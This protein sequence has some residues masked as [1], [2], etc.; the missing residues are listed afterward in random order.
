V[1]GEAFLANVR[2]AVARDRIADPGPTPVDRP[3]PEH[4]TDLIATFQYNLA[5]VGGTVYE[6]TSA[7]DVFETIEGI[8]AGL[9]GDGFLSWDEERLPVPGLITT[10]IAAGLRRMD[11]SVP[12]GAR[13]RLA[14]QH[15]YFEC[16]LGITG[17][18]A[19]LAETGSIVLDSGP[20]K[21]RMASLIPETHIALLTRDSM[22]PSLATWIND[23]PTALGTAANWTI[24]TGPSRTADIEMVITHGVHGPRNLHVL[25]V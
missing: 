8:A 13:E 12:A 1:K 4:A 9:G 24:V 19:G 3:P 16:G 7:A 5:L 6:T 11:H 23:R 2:T 17:A 20:G 10:A 14:H 18:V 15:A 25:L 22:Y 21:P